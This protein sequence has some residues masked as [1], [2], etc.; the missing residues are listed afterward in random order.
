[1][2]A[3]GRSVASVAPGRLVYAHEF[4]WDEGRDPA[5][6]RL[7][8]VFGWYGAPDRLAVAEGSGTLRGTPP[9]SSHC[10]NIGPLHRG[11]IYPT[12]A[13]WFG[14]PIPEEYSMRRVPDE[15][16]CLTPAP[17]PEVRPRPL[18]Q[19]AAAAAGPRAAQAR[20]PPGR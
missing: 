7:Q 6:P 17:I 8:R 3:Q 10:N 15:L 11:R 12:L 18:H 1:G 5:W 14:M 9:E 16:L 20:P 19:L 4:A 2:V 13:R